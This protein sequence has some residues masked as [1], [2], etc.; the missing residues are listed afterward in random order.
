MHFPPT[1]KIGE[2]NGQLKSVP[3][4]P[5]PTDLQN[6]VSV[7]PERLQN[8]GSGDHQAPQET[9]IEP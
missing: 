3:S 9:T 8:L 6:L 1:Q 7:V 2:L 5:K 4:S